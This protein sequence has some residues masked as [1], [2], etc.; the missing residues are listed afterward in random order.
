MSQTGQINGK[1][2]GWKTSNNKDVKNRD[3][4]E[5]IYN[6]LQS[7]NLNRLSIQFK[8]VF[9]HTSEPCGVSKDSLKYQIWLGNK[10]VDENVQKILNS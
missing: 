6:N 4:I 7:N 8:H 10:I 2:N 3:I 9:S 1:K 5:S